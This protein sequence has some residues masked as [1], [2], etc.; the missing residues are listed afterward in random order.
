MDIKSYALGFMT[1]KKS[2]G[3]GGAELN[4]AYGDTPPEDTSK[5]WVKTSEP[6]GLSVSPFVPRGNGVSTKDEMSI[7][8]LS[9]TLP[10]SVQMDGIAC[11]MVGTD[12]YLFGCSHSTY[13]SYIWRFSTLNDSL[14]VIT[15]ANTIN[16]FNMGCAA[17][18]SK[19]YLFGGRDSDTTPKNTIYCF[20]TTTN[21]VTKI[22]AAIPQNLMSMSCVAV[23]SKIYLLGGSRF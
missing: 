18:G 8:T 22:E 13:R 5:L 1:G 11:A 16:L 19:I 10:S 7:T 3:G 15:T 6:S 14:S 21:A 2:G 20:D 17:V 23:D 4:I 12:I 9:A